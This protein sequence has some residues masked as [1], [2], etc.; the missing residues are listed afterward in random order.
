MADGVVRVVSAAAFHSA[1]PDVK[2]ERLGLHEQEVL[3]Q[4]A[5]VTYFDSEGRS[6]PWANPDRQWGPAEPYRAASG[7]RPLSARELEAIEWLEN[8]PTVGAWT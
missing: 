3:G 8:Q 6:E 5:F 1:F 4:A 7:G 2:P